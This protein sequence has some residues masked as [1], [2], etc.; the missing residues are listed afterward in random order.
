MSTLL[1]PTSQDTIILMT[2]AGTDLGNGDASHRL[3]ITAVRSGM[4]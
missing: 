1:T 2:C 3:I 4:L